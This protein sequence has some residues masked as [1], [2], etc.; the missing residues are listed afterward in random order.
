[1]YDADS[2]SFEIEN[3]GR[4]RA[5]M[6][7][8]TQVRGHGENAR[9]SGE[10]ADAARRPHPGQGRAGPGQQPSQ[11]PPAGVKSQIRLSRGEAA[12]P[13][14]TDTPTPPSLKL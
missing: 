4:L 13:R 2:I 6:Q 7:L 1:M 14:K 8:F 12:L 10:D 11:E 3:T 5:E 9:S